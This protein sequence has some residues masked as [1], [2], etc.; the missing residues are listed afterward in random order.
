MAEFE[1]FSM[2]EAAH[3]LLKKAQAEGIGPRR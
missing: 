2:D 1:K 3:E